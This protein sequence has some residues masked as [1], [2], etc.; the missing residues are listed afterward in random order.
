MVAI[1]EVQLGV[2]MSRETYGALKVVAGENDLKPTTFV[3]RLIEQVLGLQ[4][5]L[6]LPETSQPPIPFKEPSHGA[7]GRRRR[8]AA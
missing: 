7:P 6:K 3:R 1:S 2:R 5:R 8:K 4:Q